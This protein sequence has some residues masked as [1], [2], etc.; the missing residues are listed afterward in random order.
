MPERRKCKKQTNLLRFGIAYV[1]IEALH[2]NFNPLCQQTNYKP[3]DLLMVF[4]FGRKHWSLIPPTK[5]K[6]IP[7]HTKDSQQRITPK[8]N[9]QIRKKEERER[10]RAPNGNIE[11]ESTKWKSRERH[12]R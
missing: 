4:K 1:H 5:P 6:F 11:R 8:S 12:R 2:N 3:K 10:E 7:S 9:P